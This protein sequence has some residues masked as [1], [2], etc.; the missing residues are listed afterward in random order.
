MSLRDWSSPYDQSIVATR[1][2]KKKVNL[3]T[4]ENVGDDDSLADF[5]PIDQPRPEAPQ[6]RPDQPQPRV[7]E[8]PQVDPDPY[9]PL[10]VDVGPPPDLAEK[11]AYMIRLLE[12]QRDEKTG[13]VTEE[14]ILYLFLGIFVIFIVD[15]FV[16]TG[17]YSR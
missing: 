17:R 8:P 14:I 6:P 10:S 16:K 9:P 1:A 7:P 11:V 15:T 2:A 12:E 5:K 3:T 4:L 13:H